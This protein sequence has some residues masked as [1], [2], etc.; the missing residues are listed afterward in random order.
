MPRSGVAVLALLLTLSGAARSEPVTAWNYHP[1]PPFLT[2]KGQGLAAD[3]VAALNRALPAGRTLDLESIERRRLNNEL[4]AGASGVI[5]LAN[6]A[7]F[8]DRECRHY[9]V[10]RPLLW[11]RDDLVSPAGRPIEYREPENLFGR[12]LAFLPGFRLDG[13]DAHI[14]AGRILR[15]DSL[16]SE[17]NLKRLLRGEIDVAVIPRTQLVGIDALDERFYVSTRPLSRHTRHLLFTPD[18]R[19]LYGAVEEI[20]AS[21]DFD[22]AWQAVVEGYDLAVLRVTRDDLQRE[23][24]SISCLH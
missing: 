5:L 14:R 7:W 22:R 15:S 18:Q 8:D 13:L 17:S 21:E 11:V 4:G 23:A 24:A 2:G 19:Q 6:P 20:L 9:L 10:N 16:T 12:K 1:W 3:V